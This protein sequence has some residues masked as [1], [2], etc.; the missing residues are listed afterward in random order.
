M[1]IVLSKC[2]RLKLRFHEVVGKSVEQFGVGRRV[3]GPHVVERFDQP[4]AHE[5]A[6]DEAGVAGMRSKEAVGKYY[7][8][9]TER[10]SQGG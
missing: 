10:M 6:P 7:R 1:K 9:P 4:A 5:I 3:R 2:F 8:R